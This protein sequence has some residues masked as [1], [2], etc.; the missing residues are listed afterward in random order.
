[1]DFVCSENAQLYTN[2]DNV[3]YLSGFVGSF[4]WVLLWNE[5][6]FLITD[7]RYLANAKKLAE[8]EDFKIQDIKEIKKLAEKVTGTMVIENSVTLALQKRLK[9]VFTSATIK[10]MKEN[11]MVK[12]REIKN[13]E[14]IKKIEVAQA[15][16]D[17]VLARFWQKLKKGMTEKQAAWIL[18]LDLR[19][20]NKFGLAFG[21]IVA[22]GNNTASPHHHPSDKKLQ[23]GDAILVDCGVKYQNYCSDFTRCAVFGEN[24]EYEK[25]YDDVLAVQNETIKE[26]ENQNNWKSVAEYCRAKLKAKKT[27][28]EKNYTHSLGHGVGLEVHESPSLSIKSKDEIKNGQV[29]TIEPGVY[30]SG[31][32]ENFGVRIE[33]LIVIEN[34]KPRILSRLSK[35]LVKIAA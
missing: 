10:V 2:P 22:F 16:A 19:A 26:I 34:G 31:D 35:K 8:K 3:L 11:V 28:Y 15:H 27:E 33:D 23:K 1:M 9:K 5:E 29:I 32:P 6:K 17:I 7:G 20:E 25:L 13:E 12:A 18:E 24:K 4:G 21:P 30:L 14:E